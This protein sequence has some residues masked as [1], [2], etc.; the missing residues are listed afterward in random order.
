MRL[1]PTTPTLA[2]AAAAAATII[3]SQSALAILPPSAAGT[4][5]IT[6]TRGGQ[7]CTANLMLQPVRLAQSAE[8]LS[9]GAARYQGVCVDSADGSWVMQ[10]GKEANEARLAWRLEYDKST[11]YFSADLSGDGSSGDGTVFAAPRAEP[12]ALKRVG[13]FSARKV[14][15]SWDLRDPVVAKRVTDKML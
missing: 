11:V 15:S 10:E 1:V 4:W 3:A 2:A 6:E 13:T 5:A 9:R 12:K 8:D 14:T 7:R